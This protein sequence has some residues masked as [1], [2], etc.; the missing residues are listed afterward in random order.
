MTEP[1]PPEAFLADYAPPIRELAQR[2]RTIVVGTVPDV[3]ERVRPGWRLIGYDAPDGRR[4]T[5]FAWVF[6]EPVHVHL[7]FVEGVLM[8]D[9]GRHLQGAGETKKARWLT[10]RPGDDVD[11]DLVAGL[12]REGLRVAAMSKGERFALAMSLADDP[13]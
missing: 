6:P 1:I 9:I 8:D 13:G 2:L 4:T 3:V 11:T 10:W 12:V 7:G 5:Y